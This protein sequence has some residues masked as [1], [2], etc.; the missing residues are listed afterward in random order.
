MSSSAQDPIQIGIN[1]NEA[2]Q[3]PPQYESVINVP[4]TG[5][6]SF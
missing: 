5:N 3:H 4:V 2:E 1:A 6:A